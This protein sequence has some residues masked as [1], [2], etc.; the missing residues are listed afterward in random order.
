MKKILAILLAVLLTVGVL[1]ALAACEKDK[2]IIIRVLENDT[3]KRK[4]TWTTCSTPSMKNTQGK[5][6]RLWTP[7]W[8]N[9]PTWNWTVPTDTVPTCFIRQTTYL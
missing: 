6:L 4:V 7:T 2:E 1:F 8:T 5:T 3:A 9:I